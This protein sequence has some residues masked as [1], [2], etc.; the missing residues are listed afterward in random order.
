MSQLVLVA[1]LLLVSRSALADPIQSDR[2]TVFNAAGAI[3]GQVGVN[4]DGSIFGLNAAVLHT[5][6]NPTGSE[7]P[8]DVYY[9]N[10]I[11]LPD[12]LRFGFATA[13]LEFAGGAVSDLFGVVNV[14]SVSAPVYG[15][16]FA[17]DSEVAPVR[18][19]FTSS[20]IET[21][22]PVSATSYLAAPLRS[23]GYTATF[24]SDLSEVP[25]PGS[26]PLFATCL[27]VLGY[28]IRKRVRV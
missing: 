3:V 28:S 17:S 6:P 22:A 1:V 8:S 20:L 18:F 15:L 25:E 27:A 4:E 2:L 9:I 19:S 11:T 16:G 21:G 26:W 5:F 24:E 14:G 7:A 10:D 12:P 23:A 13:L